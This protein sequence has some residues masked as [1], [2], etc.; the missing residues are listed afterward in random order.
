MQNTPR[1]V[2]VQVGQPETLDF[3]GR[4]WTSAIDKSS[5]MGRVALSTKNLMGDRQY[6]LKY[7]G[8]VDKA[9]CCYCAVHYPMW[10]ETLGKDDDFKYGAFGENFTVSGMLEEE[11]CIG[12]VYAVGTAIVQV[13]QPRQPCINLARKW[14]L[15]TLPQQMMDNGRTG[16]YLRVKQTGE[17]G[18][19]DEIKLI[20]RPCPDLSVLKL[21]WAMYQQEGGLELFA[22]LAKLPELA[23][24]GRRVFQRMLA[25]E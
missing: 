2:A 24:S 14:D 16:Y 8:G 5:V 18:V 9:V 3:H 17:V 22:R 15:R 20:E 12:D 11:V 7:H 1:L 4:Q 25:A 13:S 21:N 23:A 6:N 10:R 19:G